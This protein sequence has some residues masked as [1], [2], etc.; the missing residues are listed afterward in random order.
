MEGLGVAAVGVFGALAKAEDPEAG[1][2]APWL[3]SC[4]VC[5]CGR[6]DT[7]HSALCTLHRPTLQPFTLHSPHSTL[8][9][10]H[11]SA[12]RT[13]HFRFT[14]TQNTLHCK[15]H[16]LHFTL[17]TLHST[18]HTLHFIF[19]TYTLHSICFVS[20]HGRHGRIL[21]P[22]PQLTCIFERDRNGIQKNVFPKASRQCF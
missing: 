2:P 9:T 21:H 22:W 13:L 7:P 3:L 4:F 19:Y 5:W 20:H 12:L 16:T 1:V 8:S 6:L 18:V 10:P 17:H 11:H 14:P 15:L